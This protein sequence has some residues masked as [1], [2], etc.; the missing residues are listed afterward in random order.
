M[1]WSDLV[2]LLCL[3]LLGWALRRWLNQHPGPLLRRPQPA[4]GGARHRTAVAPRR[5]PPPARAPLSPRSP[6]APPAALAPRGATRAMEVC[7]G[8]TESPPEL[9]ALLEGALA[10]D[11]RRSDLALKLLELY[12]TAAR[13]QD[14][15]RI[16]EGFARHARS[17]QWEDVARM[18]RELAPEVPLYH[19][20]APRAARMGGRRRH[21]E[22]A[23]LAA[24]EPQLI[25]LRRHYARLR[26]DVSFLYALAETLG[27]DIG[28]PTPLYHAAAL[29]ARLGGAQLYFKREDLRAPGTD[30]LV[31][32][33][34]QA[35]LARFCG[36]RRLVCGSASGRVAGAVAA[37][38]SGLGLKATLYVATPAATREQ[39]ALADQAARHG[40]ELCWLRGEDAVEPRRVALAEWTRSSDESFYVSGLRA[41]P[42]P[43]PAISQDLQAVI[44]HEVIRQLVKRQQAP[45]AAALVASLHS[46][47]AAFGFCQPWLDRSGV[48]LELVEAAAADGDLARALP[49]RERQLLAASGRVSFVAVDDAASAEAARLCAD[50]EHLFLRPPNARALAHGLQLARAGHARQAVVVLFGAAG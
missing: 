11:P 15:R 17:G 44:G 16:A 26:H 36:K 18:G 14:F 41:G 39:R 50:H 29:S 21:Y 25:E 43:Y 24:L 10:D 37:V 22:G 48:R 46:G 8:T 30:D 4:A 45:E 19:L 42:D 35:L 6:V 1:G 28:G 32:A 38:A 33:L 47:F 23:E 3:L 5:T 34:G 40:A 31:N 13:A 20:A 2:L 9:A 27:S 7:E 49:R 12:H